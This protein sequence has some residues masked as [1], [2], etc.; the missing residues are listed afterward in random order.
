MPD[1]HE[2]LQDDD[3]FKQSTPDLSEL[4]PQS[5]EPHVDGL[6]EKSHVSAEA[7]KRIDLEAAETT[8]VVEE[9]E[10]ASRE[11]EV[12]AIREYLLD[13]FDDPETQ[14]AVQTLARSYGYEVEELKKLLP[15]VSGDNARDLTTMRR[16]AKDLGGFI[17]NRKP[18]LELFDRRHLEVRD[19][20]AE[21]MSQS[22][23]GVKEVLEKLSVSGELEQPTNL[24][25]RSQLPS[26]PYNYMVA[27]PTK[28]NIMAEIVAHLDEDGALKV[29]ES[30]LKSSLGFISSNH[31]ARDWEGSIYHNGGR[32]HGFEGADICLNDS[33]ETDFLNL[34]VVPIGEYGTDL[35]TRLSETLRRSAMVLAGAKQYFREAEEELGQEE[36]DKF[37]RS[38][39]NEPGD[40]ATMLL[41][42][43]GCLSI[44]QTITQLT[45][46]KIEGYEYSTDDKLIDDIVSSGL[47]EQMARI[48]P[49]SGV[50]GPMTIMG[51]KFEDLVIC[52]DG[53]LKL[54]RDII[55]Q[56]HHSMTDVREGWAILGIERNSERLNGNFKGCPAAIRIDGEPSSVAEMTELF[57]KIFHDTGD[58]AQ[59]PRSDDSDF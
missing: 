48:M 1:S 12:Q 19:R 33:F 20:V 22:R 44:Q 6:I 36:I 16:M 9:P 49:L 34:T 38:R 31:H 55:K 15:S 54:N 8:G 10:V 2:T 41:L 50:I 35:S 26:E 29:S 28:K 14:K 11:R 24:V 18:T 52:E 4:V 7:E 45:A 56:L 17:E 47:I 3:H 43:E 39:D 23:V 51:M 27:F 5:E 25:L 46:Q 40:P 30:K 57:V 59:S 13:R 37:I 42:Y 53:K 58:T 32:P 21:V